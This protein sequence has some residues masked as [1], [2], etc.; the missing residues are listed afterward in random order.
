MAEGLRVSKRRAF[1][2]IL[3]TIWLY[4]LFVGASATVIRAAVMGTIVVVGQR[5]ERPAHASSYRIDLYFFILI[6]QTP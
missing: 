1:W 6:H 3:A 4:T 5:L 2:P